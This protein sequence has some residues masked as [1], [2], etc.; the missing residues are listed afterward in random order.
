M[1]RLFRFWFGE[2]DARPFAAVRMTVAGAGIFLWF[3]T[4]RTLLRY[5]SDAGE[6]P[7]EAARGWSSE[8]VARFAMPDWLGA[9]AAVGV[10]SAVQLFFLITLLLGYRVRTSAVVTA[11]L[12]QWFC[13][14]NPILANGGDEILRLLTLSLAV[15]YVAV[16]ELSGIWSLD[17]RRKSRTEER[18]PAWP[19]RLIQIQIVIVYTEAGYWKLVGDP[20]YTGDA[21]YLALGNQT[22]T[23]FGVPAWAGLQTPFTVATLA[24][25]LWEALFALLVIFP[26]TRRAA[27]VFGVILHLGIL[28]FMNIGVFPVVMLAAYPAF[29]A[30]REVEALAAWAGRWAGWFRRAFSSAT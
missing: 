17:G 24:I 26:H 30:G 9:P 16:P 3:G 23:R 18:I 7:I 11:I 13:F 19:L 1:N 4:V 5:Y 27:L 2:V 25:T 29:L 12:A 28:A 22:F 14:R 20:W 15:A 8:W 10:L 6:F 21:L